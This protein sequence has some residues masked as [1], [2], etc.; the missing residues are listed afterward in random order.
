MFQK[1]LQQTKSLYPEAKITHA[2]LEIVPSFHPKVVKMAYSSVKGKGKIGV[3]EVIMLHLSQPAIAMDTETAKKITAILKK[4]PDVYG[5][6]RTAVQLM[7]D[8]L[9]QLITEYIH[10]Y[11]YSYLPSTF[12]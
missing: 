7:I 8:Q 6:L 12:L 1:L 10:L 9:S 11:T 5:K 3:A 4:Y 2:F